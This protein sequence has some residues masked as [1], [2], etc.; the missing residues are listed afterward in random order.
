MH[1]TVYRE[2]KTEEGERE[3]EFFLGGGGVVVL[4]VTL[5]IQGVE[6]RGRRERGT[7]RQEEGE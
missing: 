4:D 7:E 5:Y 6:N 1:A 3:R 2:W